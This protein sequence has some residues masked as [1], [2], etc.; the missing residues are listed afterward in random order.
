MPADALSEKADK[1]VPRCTMARRTPGR[2]GENMN[3]INAH[4]LEKAP[5]RR[6]RPS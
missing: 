3:C 4:K 6:P 2:I 5:N 1:P